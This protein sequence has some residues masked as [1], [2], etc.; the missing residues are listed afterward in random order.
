MINII[1]KNLKEILN[2]AGYD[3]GK[4]ITTLFSRVKIGEYNKYITIN[5]IKKAGFYNLRYKGEL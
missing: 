4:N 2:C 3:V 5:K 1:L